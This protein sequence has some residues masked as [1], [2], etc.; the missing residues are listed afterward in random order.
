MNFDFI[1]WAMNPFMLMFL[2]VFTGMLLGKLLK[3]GTSGAL[4]TGLGIGWA[5]MKA[6]NKVVESGQGNVGAAEK[7]LK[8]S[9]VDKG[10]FSLFLILFVAAVGLLA[11]E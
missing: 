9:V 1:K 5:I 11:A 6:A 10:F 7:L 8:V 2:A 3:I 4:F